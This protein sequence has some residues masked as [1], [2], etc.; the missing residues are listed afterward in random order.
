MTPVATTPHRRQAILDA[1]L[2]GLLE[3]GLA[4]AS[5]EELRRRSGASVGS[6]YHWIPGGKEAIAAALFVDTLATYQRRF[7]DTLAGAC[8]ARDGVQSAVRMHL[9]WVVE[10]PDRARY[11]LAGGEIRTAARAQLR[12]PNAAFFAAVLAWLERHDIA[13][14]PIALLAA[15]WLGPS[16]E[17]TR[18]WLEGTTARPPSAHTEVLA[19]AAWTALTQ[20][21]PSRCRS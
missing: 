9:E 18:L 7:L 21:A 3:H 17:L 11:L 5:I 20:A 14:I 16:Q 13:G 15:L 2:P 6:I 10:H 1:A 19:E 12:E 4:G 8:D